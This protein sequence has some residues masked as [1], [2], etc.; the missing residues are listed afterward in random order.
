MMNLATSVIAAPVIS[1]DI[2]PLSPRQAPSKILCGSSI[3]AKPAG[4]TVVQIAYNY[5]LNWNYVA[6][7]PSSVS[8]ICT[9]TPQGVAYGLADSQSS[10]IIAD[11]RSFDTTSTLGYVTTLAILYVP[12]NQVNTKQLEVR[13]PN[14]AQYQNPNP[15]VKKLMSL[16][17]PAI[18]I[19]REMALSLLPDIIPTL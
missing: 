18:N 11:L 1:T 9:Y 3:P 16:I 19:T 6:A 13:T 5:Q 2:L 14:S 17:N 7:N 15:T 10:V 12:S 8:Q 4:S